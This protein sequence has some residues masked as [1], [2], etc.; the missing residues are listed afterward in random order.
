MLLQP[1][2]LEQRRRRERR[3]EQLVASDDG[4]ADELGHDDGGDKHNRAREFV[5][6][7]DRADGDRGIEHGDDGL[8]DVDVELRYHGGGYDDE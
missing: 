6:F 1:G 4:R 2:R 3:R 7:D 5:E 8:H